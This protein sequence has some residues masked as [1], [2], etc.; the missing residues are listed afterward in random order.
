MRTYL[1][2]IG[3]PALLLL[4]VSAS[5]LALTPTEQADGFFTRGMAAETRGDSNVARLC[6]QLALRAQPAHPKAQVRLKA[7]D[8]TDAANGIQVKEK[9]KGDSTDLPPQGTRR[10]AGPPSN[11]PVAGRGVPATP[12]SPPLWKSKDGKSVRGEFVG[13]DGEAVVIKRDGKEVTLPFNRLDAASVAQARDSAA[14]RADVLLHYDFSDGAGT[15]VKDR[16][17]KGRDGTL[18]GFAK[19]DADSGANGSASGWAKDGSLIFD[20]IDDSVVTP[21]LMS[22]LVS[23]PGFT[24]EA[25]V[26]HRNP[27]GNWSSIVSTDA[28]SVA[29]GAIVQFGKIAKGGDWYCPESAVFA[30]VNGLSMPVGKA[31]KPTSLGDGGLHH[32]AMTYDSSAGVIRIYYDHQ[33]HGAWHDLTGSILTGSRVLVGNNGWAQGGGWFGPISEVRISRRPLAPGQFLAYPKPPD[34]PVPKPAHRYSFNGDANDS[35]GTAHGHVVDAGSPT[36]RF[37]EGQ[38]DLS[39]NRGEPSRAIKE[40]AYVDLPNG[41]IGKL[42]GRFTLELWCTMTR[43]DG[44]IT[45]C[46]FGRSAAGENI[47]TDPAVPPY[48]AINLILKGTGNNLEN[49]ITLLDPSAPEDGQSRIDSGFDLPRTGTERHYTLAVDISDTRQGPNGSQFLYVD[50]Y[51]VGSATLPPGFVQKLEDLNNWLGRAQRPTQVFGGK[52]NEFR[53]HDRP[54]TA[55]EVLSSHIAGPDAQFKTK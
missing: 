26:G 42:K 45:A 35:I 49:Y 32:V 39:A 34:M 5:V 7:L 3:M 51:L 47:S 23:G 8:K 21:L 15:S 29:T 40:D 17:G 16:S 36:A 41:L 28:L 43:W 2:R 6:Y 4:G 24:L 12:S 54:L 37:S 44:W 9:S 1:K 48:G 25:V 50:G 19:T 14:V 18:V 46:S 55:A 31:K 33:L 53:V 38:L 10:E 52:Y 27:S 22:D 20:G 11:T 30:R 13:L